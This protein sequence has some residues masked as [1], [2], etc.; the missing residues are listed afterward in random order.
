[1][2]PHWQ[3]FIVF[4][5]NSDLYYAWNESFAQADVSSRK[6]EQRNHHGDR[7]NCAPSLTA[8]GHL[9]KVLIGALACHLNAS[10]LVQGN[11]KFSKDISYAVIS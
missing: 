10:D 1:M 5:T 8:K 4:G 11:N 6:S 7:N 2:E 9:G 3:S